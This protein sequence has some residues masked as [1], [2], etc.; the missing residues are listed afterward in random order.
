[1][2][3]SFESIE[4]KSPNGE[5]DIIFTIGTGKNY[6]RFRTCPES[7]TQVFKNINTIPNYKPGLL[8]FQFSYVNLSVMN[9][10]CR[11]FRVNIT[12]RDNYISFI[13]NQYD[14]YYRIKKLTLSKKTISKASKLA[15]QEKFRK[16]NYFLR[17]RHI[18]HVRSVFT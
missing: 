12:F 5:N 9:H 16:N 2:L 15:K 18:D 8:V 13:N 7:P 1:M 4:L 14:E 17:D 10:I 6:Q 3:P 11:H